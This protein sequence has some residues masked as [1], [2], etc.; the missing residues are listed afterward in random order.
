MRKRKVKTIN[1]LLAIILSGLMVIAMIPFTS[2]NTIAA[3][4]DIPE[5][6]IASNPG[7]N[8]EGEDLGGN[9]QNEETVP[10]KATISVSV[11]GDAVV[12]MNGIEQRSAV[13]DIGTDVPIKITP[14]DGSYIK[15]LTVGG[16]SVD[17]TKGEIYEGII[18]AAE[19]VVIVAD[20]VKEFRV[21]APAVEGGIVTLNGENISSILVDENTKVNIG[22]IAAEGYQISSIAIAGVDQ[23]FD[24]ATAFTKEVF[25]NADIEITVVFTKVYS[26]TVTHNEKGTVVTEP[27][28]TGGS[29]IVDEGSTVKLTA[30]PDDNYRISEVIINDIADTSITGANFDSEDKYIKELK[31]DKNYTV[32]ITFAP[33]RYRVVAAAMENGTVDIESEFVDYN[34]SARVA[35]LPD[36]GYTIESVKV[37]DVDTMV[38]APDDTTAYFMIEG[39]VED[40]EVVVSFRKA[41]MADMDHVLF[42][43][44]DALRSDLDGTFYVFANDATVTFYT[45]KNGIRIYDTDDNWIGGV[46]NENSVVIPKTTSIGKISLYYKAEEEGIPAWHDVTAISKSKP[47]NIV[48]DVNPAQ[49]AVTP[50]APNAYGYYNSNLSVTVSTED[51]GIYSGIASVE[52]WIMNDAVETKRETLYNYTAD[53][54]ILNK[55][56]GNILVDAAAN[57]SD[58]VTVNV[59]VT[60]RAG[61]VETKSATLAINSTKPVV[62]VSVDGSLHAEAITGKYNSDRTATITYI[63]RATTFDEAAALEGIVISAKN[64]AGNK[65]TISKASMITW[66]HSGDTHTATVSFTADANYEW[67]VSYTNKAGLSDDQIETSGDSVY[68]FAVDKTAPAAE[69]TLEK[70]TWDKLI[71]TLTFGI[72]KKYSVTVEAAGSDETTDIG[73]IL[74]Y[75]S[76][77]T[78]ALDR[79]QLEQ[80]FKDGKFT[81]D[82]ITVSADERFTVYAR[83]TDQ[84]GNA[85]Y[86][87]TNGVIYDSSNSIIT[88]TPPAANQH[89][90]YNKDVVIPISVNEVMNA[91]TAY[92]GIKSIS[93]IVEKDGQKTQEGTL[94]TYEIE[95]P[96]YGQLKDKW[97]G[98]ITVDSQKNNSDNT[99]VTVKA[100]DNAGNEYEKSVVL[101][102]NIDQPVSSIDFAD[103]PNKV[104]DNHGYYGAPR[105][106]VITIADRATSFDK[107]AATS[108]ICFSAV[109][110]KGK[111]VELSDED[112][113][114]SD[115]VNSGDQHTA[116]V[117]FNKDGN[118]TWSFA[119]T[120]KADNEM[121]EV[122]VEPSDS[123]YSFTVD[124]TDPTGTVTVNTNTWDKLLQILTFGLYSNAKADVIATADDAVSPYI[125]EYFETSNPIAM[126]MEELDKETFVPYEDYSI[127]NDNQFV[128]YLKIKDYAGNYT[129][130]NSD[131]YIVDKVAS[132][133]VLTPP[134][135]NGFYCA[136]A[137]ENGQ[138]GLY[139]RKSD[140]TID[141]KIEDDKPYSGIKTVEY[142]VEN[143]NVK[144]QEGNL[145]TFDVENPV[146]KELVEKW[147][148]SIT[149]DKSL[150]NSC[151]VVVYVKTV[152]NAGNENV[153]SVKLDID[154]TAPVIDIAFDN[155]KDNN[156][157]TYFNAQRTATV[158]I[159]ERTHHFDEDA[160][161]EG[162]VVQ[163]VDAK[164]N[165][166]EKAYTISGWTTFENPQNPDA[167]THMA[168]IF[169]E[170]DA[171]YTWSLMYTDKSGNTNDQVKLAEGTIAAFDFTVDTTAP[172]GTVK[173]VSSEGRETEWSS[174][175]D[176]LTFGFWS[177]ERIT[178][179]STSD[180][181]TSAP[182]AAVE[183]YKVKAD[184]P[185]DG[186]TVLTA[187]ELDQ[188]S[189]S[190][191]DGLEIASD[192]QFTVYI[193]IT[194][195]AG[196][197]TYIC[198]NGLIVDHA[199]PVEET[200]APE[201]SI[202]PQQPING[203]YNGDVKVAIKVTDPIVGGTYSGL[204]TVAYKV[205]NMGTVTQTGTLYSFENADPKQSDLLQSWAGEITVDSQLNNSN[206]VVIVVYAEDNSL[207]S[208]DDD[209]AIKIDITDPM[210][211]VAY[212]NNSADNAKY[213]NDNRTATIVV[214]ERNFNAEDVNVTITNTDG[215]IPS[216]SGW[217]KTEGNGNLDDTKWS[218]TVTY[219]ADGDYTFDISYTDLADNACTGAQYGG[220]TAPTEFTVDKT[221]PVVAVSYSN[222]NARNEKYFAAPR[223]ATVTITEHNFDVNRVE[224]TQSAVL[225]GTNVA[226]PAASW[227]NNGD[228]HTATIAF[229]R[230]G[231]YTFDVTVRDMAAND[232]GEANFGNSVAG[233]DFVIDQTI[234]KPSIGGVENGKAYKSDVIPTISF[235]DVNYESYE[236]K[237]V[238]TRMGEK[239][240]DVTDQFIKGVTEQSQGGTGSY[241]T[242][243]KI[244]ENDGIYTL[245]VKMIDKAGNEE[246]VEYTFTV[247]RFGSVYEYSDYLISLLEKKY[248]K[249][250]GDNSE[251]VTKDIVITEYSASQILADSLK[252]L[253][254]RDG[255]SINTKYTANPAVNNEAAIGDSG[256]YQYVYT[257]D[258]ENFEEDGVYKIT[259]ASSYAASDSEKNES[260][261]VPENSIDVDGKQIEYTMNFIVDTTKPEIRNIVNLDQKIVNATSLDVNYTIV[262]VGGLKSIEV[263]VNG[264]AIDTI[265]EFGDSVFNYSGS[266]TLNESSDKQNVQIRATDIAGNVTDTA[267]KDFDANALY[268]FNDTVTVSTN[269]FVRWFANKP[270]F[271]GSIV[272]II[273]LAGATFSLITF[274]SKKKEDKRTK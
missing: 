208:S 196:N 35:V 6:L 210:I 216:I 60:D 7:E 8:A 207:N 139:N 191:F 21:A 137:N 266:F 12:E 68:E 248:I 169:F 65:I 15:A 255:E 82:K 203:L 244:A 257:I 240:V 219:S 115:W 247:N 112:V 126:T 205:L 51:Q 238:R 195:L 223:T 142:W 251:A 162:I 214:T 168:T 117:T 146:Q 122:S 97:T 158:V 154:N 11:T 173:A 19:D 20:V 103:V 13:V 67:S 170:K 236:V 141:I 78:D 166:V 24:N 30:D 175:R 104:V 262:D 74:Y 55:Y 264:N 237:L 48:L 100:V 66:N 230:D 215:V 14:E 172:T 152:D 37:N 232:S 130:I 99:K 178:I 124:Q 193:K 143:N 95:N 183:Y 86:I 242:F 234:E 17:V 271:V 212:D 77:D 92:S 163:A 161:T 109:D 118:Y 40:K 121:K 45:T 159:T 85:T 140:V 268:V 241:D 209:V 250:D 50:S 184:A 96:T 171:N 272:G 120:N 64:A 54:E 98:N 186:L 72:F 202:T 239:N 177:K 259:L 106:A 253:V 151:N 29:V 41:E 188:V 160:A 198:T 181:L 224:F 235:A 5:P 70:T 4:E 213:F 62:R 83:I 201:I 53:G 217:T 185:G 261:S 1:R 23:I 211:H 197:Y 200:I 273:V 131:G 226:I 174:L 180:D 129:Y 34:G 263:L 116:T 125:I 33:N 147:N 71:S 42:N 252:L 155:N 94:Y 59:A 93:Y 3:I 135:A 52:Y 192:E 27:T 80:A 228:V 206:D 76:N 190:R 108:G 145:F 189:W 58:N 227:T 114:I 123:A 225:N 38:I 254:T 256:W 132:N 199:A 233:K 267:S 149:V 39:I 157:N 56:E 258:K 246:T 182:I 111:D 138:Y 28:T 44:E 43:A 79:E 133:I 119:Y 18:K 204:K 167:A 2:V 274:K 75:K 136:D 134:T 249:I 61:N 73:D 165:K 107:E 90:Y 81:K 231:D 218:T 265:T 113:M 10:E 49:T 87:S 46:W 164:G 260:V 69:I 88:L 220:S 89:G 127:E 9:Q 84:A 47:L 179:S 57:N 25:V 150:N 156:G 221:I 243:E 194:D 91:D 270:L 105:S 102:I 187:E 222:N 245:T 144:T 101:A 31:A 229:D 153:K 110:A 128:V 36:P 176:A 63:D 26:I 148:G 32:V 269:F 16:E 22:V